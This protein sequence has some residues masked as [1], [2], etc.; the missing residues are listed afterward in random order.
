MI[1][2]L[3]LGIALSA[4]TIAVLG[5]GAQQAFAC[6]GKYCVDAVTPAEVKAA[7]VD[8]STIRVSWVEHQDTSYE[9]VD[10]RVRKGGP[11]GAESV[12][13]LTRHLDSGHYPGYEPWHVDVPNLSFNTTY[14]FAVR[15]F[16][17]N[18]TV[19]A[20]SDQVCATTPYPPFSTTSPGPAPAES[21][22]L[23]GTADR[24]KIA[25]DWTYQSAAGRPDYFIV[26]RDGTQIGSGGS[27]YS[28][29]GPLTK[30]RAYSYQVCAMYG[31]GDIRTEGICSNTVSVTAGTPRPS[32]PPATQGDWPTVATGAQGET[33][34]TIQYLLR[35]VGNDVEVDGD[36]GPQTEA[37]VKSFQAISI[38]RQDGSV[39]PSTWAKLVVTLKLGSQGEAVEAV[40]SQLIA[41]GADVALDGDFG[42]QTDAAVRGFQQAH[43]LA[44][45]GIVG[46]QTW[47]ALVAPR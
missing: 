26:K 21:L 34:R 19:S 42:P 45:D 15:T 1:R 36:F 44:V 5:A 31:T 22:K 27:S 35:A 33:V 39:G 11:N 17:D 37:A 47:Q 30:G 18:Q 8:S 25:L 2:R 41:H 32:A 29:A 23:N 38:L 13:Q 20:W 28:D 3:A 40:Q 14:C 7:P 46:P 4:S 12:T 6:S 16:G 10:V 24:D 43:G 9:K